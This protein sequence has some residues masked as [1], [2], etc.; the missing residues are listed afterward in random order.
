MKSKYKTLIV[1]CW[2][3]L[4]ICFIVK[5][6]G[7]NIFEAMTENQH[8]IEVCNWLD[9]SWFKYVVATLF[10]EFSTYLIYL[11]MCD[12]KFKEDSWILLAMLPVSLIKSFIGAFGIIFDILFMVII[13]LIVCKFKNWKKVLIGNILVFLFQI[14]SL[15]T[16][17]VGI[18]LTSESILISMIVSIDYYI[19]IILYY[20][21]GRW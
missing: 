8:F 9:N 21:Q 14:V 10:Y 6:F 1:S 15:F 3:V 17:E 18:Y 12:K 13:P 20:L 2:I 16:K 11:T 4:L 5:I 7:G 19:M